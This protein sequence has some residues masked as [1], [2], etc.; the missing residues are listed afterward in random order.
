[1][2]YLDND[3]AKFALIKGT[4]PTRNSAW[5]VQQFWEGESELGTF[6]WFGRVPSTANCADD[7]SRGIVVVT[8]SGVRSRKVRVGKRFLAAL[9]DSW[10]E[11][12]CWQVMRNT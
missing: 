4:S 6:S 1:M 5:L 10:V 9:V 8:L 3:A 11:A 12:L 2:S 7:P